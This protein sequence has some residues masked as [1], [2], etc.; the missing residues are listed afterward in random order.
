LFGATAAPSRGVA[1]ATRP[2]GPQETEIAVLRAPSRGMVLVKGGLVRVG[3]ELTEVSDA[4]RMCREEL[5]R[6]ACSTS[7]FSDE[8]VAHDVRLSDFWLDRTEVTND[9]YERCVEVGE[10]RGPRH[11]GAR[12]WRAVP[13]HPVTL[14][15]WDDAD[16]YCRWRGARLPTEAEWERAAR[17]FARRLYPWGEVYAPLL[18]NHGRAAL[19]EVERTD[20]VDGFLE[21]APVA[22]FPS[23]RTPEGVLDLAGNVSEWVADWYAEGYAEPETVDPRG[24]ASGNFKVHRGGSFIDG[25]AWLRGARRGHALPSSSAKW[26]GFRC[27][28]SG[29]PS[30]SW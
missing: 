18:L 7:L 6:E 5:S 21:L 14:V 28:T 24:P 15:T 10:C 23:A 2:A 25:R 19:L 17:G 16:R 3:S 27:A 13:A 20:D 11:V 1:H 12:R 8:M 9:A 22:S 26:L 29:R 4:Q 30:R